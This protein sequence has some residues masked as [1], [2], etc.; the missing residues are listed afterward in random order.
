MADRYS[1]SRDSS[2]LATDAGSS[3]SGEEECEW[4]SSSSYDNPKTDTNMCSSDES[5]SSS[6]PSDENSSTSISSDSSDETSST[7]ISSDSECD[8]D[9]LETSVTDPELIRE[10][11][12]SSMKE[13]HTPLYDGA[14]LSVLD[15]HLLMY[16][17]A[18][19]HCITTQAFTELIS[20]VETH[21]PRN[22]RAISSLYKLRKFFEEN[23]NDTKCQVYEYCSKCHRL[24]DSET[25]G[26]PCSSGCE[27]ATVNKFIYVPVESQLKKKLKG[28]RQHY[29]IPK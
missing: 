23:F 1:D 10:C 19:R 17:Y 20:L 9:D 5:S 25:T 26:V 15:S 16:Q 13:F 24:I 28:N 3:P 29:V 4:S 12:L 7:S 11:G 14:E 22:S 21:M 2:S 8:T 18:L 6:G 27:G